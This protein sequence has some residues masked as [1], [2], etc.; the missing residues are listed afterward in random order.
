MQAIK[1]ATSMAAQAL[2]QPDIGVLAAGKT[3]DI[4]VVKGDVLANIALL[5]T[6]TISPSSTTAEPWA[7]RCNL[8]C[9]RFLSPQC[10]AG[11]S[12]PAFSYPG[13]TSH[14]YSP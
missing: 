10:R 12:C 8:L 11:V 3:A 14:I 6:R 4:L 5:R 13:R 7:G 9:L 2:R 1:T